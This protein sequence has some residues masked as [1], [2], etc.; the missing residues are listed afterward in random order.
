VL[1]LG[2]QFPVAVRPAEIFFDAL[3]SAGVGAEIRHVTGPHSASTFTRGVIELLTAA[4][5]TGAGIVLYH[6][7]ESVP[8][9]A[10]SAARLAH[11]ARLS[12]VSGSG[13]APR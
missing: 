8:L 9:D 11:H 10:P 13:V 7:G 12:W 6:E 3:R 2:D 5:G 1:F 4:T